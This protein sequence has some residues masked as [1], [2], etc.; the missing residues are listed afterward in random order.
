MTMNNIGKQL[1]KLP[2]IHPEFFQKYR[3]FADDVWQK[4]VLSAKEKEIIAV[5]V[6][7]VTKCSYCTDFHSKKAKRIG[8]TTK[9]LVEG[10]IIATSIETGTA[11]IPTISTNIFQ[12]LGVESQEELLNV[13][14]PDQY[15]NLHDLLILP[16][17][18][19]VGVLPTKLVILISYAVAHALRSNEY[20]EKLQTVASKYN[21]SEIELGEA[22][23]IAAALRAG[24]T[25]RH[26]ADVLDVVDGERSSTV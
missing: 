18:D 8:V 24:S 25:V 21:V 20:V 12:T 26:L 6:T 7:T 17:V 3:S 16:F 9:E 11:L 15:I 10:V 5:S 4:G 19:S 1:I 23:L 22:S 2:S 13:L 14:F